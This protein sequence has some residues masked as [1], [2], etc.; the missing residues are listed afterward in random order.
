MK[1]TKEAR[2]WEDLPAK[3]QAFVKRLE[4]LT[5]APISFV[6]VGPEREQI[7]ILEE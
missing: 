2:T 4:E 6:S 1:S 7:I 5:G 3:A